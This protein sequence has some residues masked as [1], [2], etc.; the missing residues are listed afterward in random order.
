MTEL[1][2]E[3][4]EILAPMILLFFLVFSPALMRFIQAKL[5]KIEKTQKAKNSASLPAEPEESP[6]LLKEG[7]Q[8]GRLVQDT[9]RLKN[10][11]PRRGISIAGNSTF[12]KLEKF[13]P[14]Q[15]AVIWAEILGPPGGKSG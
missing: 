7:E 4:R 13:P 14:L 11:Y 1:W 5:I 3:L 10:R 2:K 15:K 12:E 8:P 6:A 9:P